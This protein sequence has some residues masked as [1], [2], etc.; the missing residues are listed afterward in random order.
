MRTSILSGLVDA[1]DLTEYK[2]AS[3][4]LSS[5]IEVKGEIEEEIKIL[6]E[7]NQSTQEKEWFLEWIQEFIKD[8]KDYINRPE[9][10]NARLISFLQRIYIDPDMQEE[11]LLKILRSRDL[12]AKKN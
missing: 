8:T 11:Q 4:H 12:K 9:L 3:S 5:L 7:A 1:K 6:L 10:R 2:E